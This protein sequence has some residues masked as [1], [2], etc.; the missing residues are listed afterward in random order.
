M[1]ASFG[2]DRELFRELVSLL[3]ADYPEHLSKICQAVKQGD[4]EALE[5]AAHTLKGAIGNF[6]VREPFSTAFELETMDR[7]GQLQ[8]SIEICDVLERQLHHL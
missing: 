1:L 7:E 8:G 6:A 2:G 3:V 5:R 4:G